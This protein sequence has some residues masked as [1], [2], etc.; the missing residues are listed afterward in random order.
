MP[1]ILAAVGLS[2]PAVDGEA[3]PRAASG[4]SP[5]MTQPEVSTVAWGKRCVA[6][7]VTL[8][9]WKLILITRNYAGATNA[10][11]LYNLAT[12]PVEQQNLATENPSKVER[13]RRVLDERAP[14]LDQAT[15]DTEFDEGGP[16]D[17]HFEEQLR[18]L[19]YVR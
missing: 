13:L 1:S 4:A 7:S 10:V 9:P 19:G 2:S 6:R 11:E 15:V 8:W 17:D 18:S 14:R 16:F 5:E 12:D 3:L